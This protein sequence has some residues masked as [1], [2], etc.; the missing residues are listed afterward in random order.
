MPTEA[1]VGA[2]DDE[3]QA[4]RTVRWLRRSGLSVRMEKVGRAF[5][6][7]VPVAVRNGK[8]TGCY[9]QSTGPANAP[10]WSN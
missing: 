1:I 2:F 9:R 6:V 7:S 8:R 4:N 10:G 5:E 3:E